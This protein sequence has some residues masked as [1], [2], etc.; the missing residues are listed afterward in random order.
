MNVGI[1]AFVKEVQKPDIG[2]KI[3]LTYVNE[4]GNDVTITD[5]AYQGF[6][7]TVFSYLSSRV[8]KKAI[9]LITWRPGQQIKLAADTMMLPQ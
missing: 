9:F 8:N 3:H 2:N 6:V 7:S 5:F 4:N 1:K